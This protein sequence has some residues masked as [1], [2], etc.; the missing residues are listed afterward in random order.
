MY[1]T[2]DDYNLTFQG[3]TPDIDKHYG[4]F[5]ENNISY[6]YKLE[7]IKS[8]VS[9]GSVELSSTYN[10]YKT[11]LFI[12]Y[13]IIGPLDIEISFYPED[14]E[15]EGYTESTEVKFVVDAQGNASFDLKNEIELDDDIDEDSEE[16]ANF[17]RAKEMARG[18]FEDDKSVKFSISDMNLENFLETID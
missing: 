1:R 11:F 9:D 16:Y 13:K 4:E 5:E 12:M 6:D 10:E 17:E 7:K 3:N 2:N 8:L 14:E 18:M 15:E